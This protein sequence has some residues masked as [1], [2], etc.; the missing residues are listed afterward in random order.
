LVS[1]F[2]SGYEISSSGCDPQPISCGHAKKGKFNP[3]FFIKPTNQDCE[4][5]FFYE[6]D[7]RIIANPDLND[8]AK[9]AQVNYT[10]TL[11]NL[12]CR[13]LKRERKDLIVEGLNVVNDLLSNRDA[14]SNFANCELDEFN[15]KNRSYFT[16]RQQYFQAFTRSI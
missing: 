16:T 10:I 5:Y 9:L 14:L 4:D 6:L 8:P 13:R 15:G 7:G 11:L 3:L 12:N 2:N 1:C